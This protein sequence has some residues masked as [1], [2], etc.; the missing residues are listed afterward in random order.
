VFAVNKSNQSRLIE[1]AVGMW[2]PQIK[3]KMQHLMTSADSKL[4]NSQ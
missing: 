3:L 4:F 2:L 1:I